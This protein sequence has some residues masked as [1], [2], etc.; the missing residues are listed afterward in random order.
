MFAGFKVR[1]T[2]E[3]F[4]EAKDLYESGL[5]IYE[6]HKATARKS[7]R[8]YLLNNGSLSADK[9]EKEWFPHF[10]A[11]VF[12]SHS[13]KDERLAITFA[14]WLYEENQKNQYL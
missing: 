3:N 2:A 6:D 7:L 12:L 10:D 14:G 8:G 4:G 5:K 1:L 13:H 11:T 9:I